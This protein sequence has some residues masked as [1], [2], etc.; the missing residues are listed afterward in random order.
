MCSTVEVPR[1]KRNSPTESIA[2]LASANDSELGATLSLRSRV[3]LRRYRP[4]PNGTNAQ[5]DGDLETF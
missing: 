2:R 1:P 3:S 4:V 5:N